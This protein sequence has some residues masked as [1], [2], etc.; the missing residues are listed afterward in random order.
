VNANSHQHALECLLRSRIEHLG[1][2]GCRIG[3]PR[4]EDQFGCRTAII[5]FKFQ[6]DEAVATVIFRQ[7]GYEIVVGGLAGTLL[8]NDDGLLVGD[9]VYK[10]T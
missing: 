1:P 3:T 10:V 7:F 5:R 9:V 4:Y 2:H 8:F 6:I